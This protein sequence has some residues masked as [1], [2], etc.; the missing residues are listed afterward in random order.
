VKS[1]TTRQFWKLFDQLPMSVQAQA[2]IGLPAL[3]AESG[4]PVLAL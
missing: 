4:A 1:Q 3:A 2:E